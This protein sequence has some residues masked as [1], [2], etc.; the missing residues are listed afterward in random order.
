MR[1]VSRS[2]DVEAMAFEVVAVVQVWL[3][4]AGDVAVGGKSRI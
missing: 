4:G 1:G 3:I 2:L